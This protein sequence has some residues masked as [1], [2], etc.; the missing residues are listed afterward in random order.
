MGLKVIDMIRPKAG[1]NSNQYQH[2]TY[3]LAIGDSP[4]LRSSLILIGCL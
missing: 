4:A 2:I 1:L 3:K